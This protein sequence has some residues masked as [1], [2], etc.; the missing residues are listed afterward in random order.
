[1]NNLA[2]PQRN[3]LGKLLSQ[4]GTKGG[5]L[6]DNLGSDTVNVLLSPPKYGSATASDLEVWRTGLVSVR[7]SS[8]QN[9]FTVSDGDISDYLNAVDEID[10]SKLQGADDDLVQTILSDPSTGNPSN[11]FGGSNEVQRIA[12][13]TNRNSVSKVEV[14]PDA[15]DRLDLRVERNSGS[16]Y[17]ELKNRVG[18]LNKDWILD[19]FEQTNN[20]KFP[21]A[22]N[23]GGITIG[24]DDIRVLE[25]TAKYSLSSRISGS[26]PSDIANNLEP[27]VQEIVNGVEISDSPVILNKIQFN[28]QSADIECDISATNTVSCT[29]GS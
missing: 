8:T 19:R 14:E 24:P 4:T 26:T 13:Y 5:E 3:D 29:V 10:G 16:D 28:L 9:G 15:N 2:T 18:Q 11:F 1:L 27:V 6:I 22:E 17:I 25:V 21:D 7:G 12:Y 23:N 20:D